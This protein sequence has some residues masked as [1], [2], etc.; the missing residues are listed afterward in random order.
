[1]RC[2]PFKL[3]KNDI[4][5]GFVGQLD[6]SF[7]HELLGKLL[8]FYPDYRFVL[9]G[10]VSN[11]AVL[12]LNE[13]YENLSL[14]GYVD[15]ENLRDYLETFTIGICPYTQA[16]FNRYRNPLKVYEYFSYG[17]P[18]VCTSCDVDPSIQHLVS[19]TSDHNEFLTMLSS[20]IQSNST[21]KENVRIRV[22]DSNCWDNRSEFLISTLKERL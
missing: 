5:I 9:V 17:L 22:A 10:P 1:M 14:A 6:N 12:N 2:A 8:S 7:D 20:E 21:E 18:V 3:S 19:I 13:R 11:D 4:V 16:D 15:Y